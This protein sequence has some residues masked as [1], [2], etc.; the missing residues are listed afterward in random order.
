MSD[1]FNL[2]QDKRCQC[3]NPQIMTGHSTDNGY[4]ITYLYCLQCYGF[5]RVISSHQHIKAGDSY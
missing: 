3:N 2:C 1:F 4:F 5:V